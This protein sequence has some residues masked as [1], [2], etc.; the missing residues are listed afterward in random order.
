M[1]LRRVVATSAA[2]L[3]ARHRVLV[4]LNAAIIILSKRTER[5]GVVRHHIAIL[6][7]PA[8]RQVRS[9]HNLDKVHIREVR[10]VGLLLGAIQRVHVVV[11]PW[12]RLGAELL[13]NLFR[14]LGPKAERVDRVPERVAAL[15]GCLPVVLEV[16]NV[17]V[18]V[19]ETPARRNV[20]VAHNFVDAQAALDA[21]PFGALLVEALSVVFARAL[22]D[23][24]ATAKRPRRLR[25]CF[26][27]LVARVA[28]AGLGGVGGGWR[29]VAVAAVGGVEVLCGFV[30]VVQGERFDVD[31]AAA[32]FG[33]AEAHF[34]DAVLHAVLLLAGYVHYI[35]GQKFAGY[36]GEGDVEVDFHA[37][38]CGKR[39]IST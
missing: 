1:A 22:L 32:L 28:A 14:Q 36:A 12:H 30:V 24:L 34:V 11:R 3:V 33:G 17:H 4:R 26:T 16:V 37:L 13:A 21:A 23:V 35:E 8:Q 2:P 5:C 20:E 31:H 6:L 9:R 10:V 39:G 25:V 27:H 29:A 7:L 19:A 15:D 38:A 18:V